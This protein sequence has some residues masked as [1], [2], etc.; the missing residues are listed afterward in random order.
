MRKYIVL[1]NWVDGAGSEVEVM[2]RNARD[3]VSDAYGQLDERVIPF[4]HN[5]KVI[6]RFNKGRG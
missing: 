6:K 2:A 4:V 5:L 3:A 1:I